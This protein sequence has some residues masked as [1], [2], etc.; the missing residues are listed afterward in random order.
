MDDVRV[1]AGRRGHQQL[2]RLCGQQEG[3]PPR[4]STVVR[5]FFHLGFHHS[6]LEASPLHVSTL[7]LLFLSLWLFGS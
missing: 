7:P 2:E 3:H 1:A 6:L 5:M 4:S